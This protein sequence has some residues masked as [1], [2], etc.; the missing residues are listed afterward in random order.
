MA[1][2]FIRVVRELTDTGTSNSYMERRILC[3][4]VDASNIPSWEPNT[5]IIESDEHVI[6]RMEL[7]GVK[8]ED[9]SVKLKNGKL[10]IIGVRWEDKPQ[11]G[12]IY[13]QLEIH[14]GQFVKV[15]S[16]P[17]SLEHNDISA[18]F[19]EGILEIRIS[20]ESNVLE[21]P[22]AVEVKNEK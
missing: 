21:I 15:I 13:H 14:Y 10:Y 1:M 8:R 16:L 4:T 2:H 12:A 7:A 3:A 20:K 6:I 9:I 5:D 11:Q 17:E 19:Q 18:S 22:I